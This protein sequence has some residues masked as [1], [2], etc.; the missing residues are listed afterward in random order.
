MQ[1][2]RLWMIVLLTGVA[3][4][5]TWLVT[6]RT[7][8]PPPLSAAATIP[9]IGDR[10][11][12]E[13]LG[14]GAVIR[15]EPPEPEAGRAGPTESA[16]CTIGGTEELHGPKVAALILVYDV[17]RSERKGNGV[18]PPGHAL[19]YGDRWEVWVPDERA[20]EAVATALGGRLELPEGFEGPPSPS[21]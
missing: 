19:V 17:S 3:A 9:Q 10:L 15:N 6:D 20:A 12:Q 11:A 7:D 16:L 14:C 2:K 13:G 8:D 5:A 4:L 1:G 21:G 18:E